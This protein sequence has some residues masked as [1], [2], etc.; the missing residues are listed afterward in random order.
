MHPWRFTCAL[1]P[2]CNASEK[3]FLSASSLRACR[4]DCQ[5]QEYPLCPSSSFQ[6]PARAGRW[7]GTLSAVCPPP[8]HPSLI[9]LVCFVS[10]FLLSYLPR[11][12]FFLS[13]WN[14]TRGRET[15]MCGTS[16]DRNQGQKQLLAG[17]M[18]AIGNPVK[19]TGILGFAHFAN[20][21]P[22]HKPAGCV[23]FLGLSSPALDVRLMTA[24]QVL[25]SLPSDS[26]KSR[27]MMISTEIRVLRN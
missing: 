19:Y 15:D 6:N 21:G 11:G 8:T 14:R 23:C 24:L 13:T 7:V 3:K 17:W 1:F 4:V 26:A 16:P 12:I 18:E 20:F 25:P 9:W 27:K 5:E 2:L 10:F 22:K